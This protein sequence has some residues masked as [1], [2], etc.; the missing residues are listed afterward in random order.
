MSAQIIRFPV[1]R[2]LTKDQALTMILR[3]IRQRF[4]IESE[5]MVIKRIFHKAL[6]AL[7]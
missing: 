1:E 2:R 4:E 5:G 3:I 7:R 6:D